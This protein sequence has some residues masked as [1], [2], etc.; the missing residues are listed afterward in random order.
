MFSAF[1]VQVP[2]KVSRQDK[3][4]NYLACFLL[5]TVSPVSKAETKLIVS[6][7]RVGIEEHTTSK[8]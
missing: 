1:L 7:V 3:V 8:H 2:I 5:I 4:T 6:R